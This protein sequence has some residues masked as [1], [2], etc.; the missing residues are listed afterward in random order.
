MVAKQRQWQY[1]QSSVVKISLKYIL[2]NCWILLSDLVPKSP[3][4]HNQTSSWKCLRCVLQTITKRSRPFG[5]VVGVGRDNRLQNAWPWFQMQQVCRNHYAC[6][7]ITH[8]Q[9]V[10]V[11]PGLCVPG[12]EED[13]MKS[14]MSG[15]ANLLST[16]E[17]WICK[18]LYKLFYVYILVR[19][20]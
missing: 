4:R 12:F 2:R 1:L 19:F 9:Y 11:R 7:F 15:W 10:C 8:F 13:M 16:N 3:L 6:F 17:F 18:V 20:F 14:R 5:L